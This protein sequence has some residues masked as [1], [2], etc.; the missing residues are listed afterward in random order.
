MESGEDD[1]RLKYKKAAE[2]GVANK[3]WKYGGEN[4]RRAIW[5]EE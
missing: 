1:R 3:V 5:E 2:D 4:L